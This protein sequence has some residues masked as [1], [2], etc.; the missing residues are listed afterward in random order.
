M[1]SETVLSSGDAI[2]TPGVSV[3]IVPFRPDHAP[4]WAALNEAW[5]AE[6]GFTV[7]DK[8]RA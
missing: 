5:L 7:E 3:L 8:D 1:T 4:T 6:G 2:P